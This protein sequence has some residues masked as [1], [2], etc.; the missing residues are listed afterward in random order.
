MKILQ[1]GNKVAVDAKGVRSTKPRSDE[2]AGSMMAAKPRR[3]PL[4]M[5]EGNKTNRASREAAGMKAGGTVKKP[6]KGRYC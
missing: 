5:G 4:A 6:G 1:A 3:T 2:E